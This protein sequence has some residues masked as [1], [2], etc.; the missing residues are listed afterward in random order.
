MH[1]FIN[2][3]CLYT[4]SQFSANVLGKEQF[5]A[6]YLC[7]G[8]FGSLASYLFKTQQLSNSMTVGASAAILGLLANTSLLAPNAQFSIIFLPFIKFS[9]QYFL[10]GIL[11]FDAAGIAL[12]WRVMDHAAHLGGTLFGWSVLSK[13]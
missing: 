2:M 12:G 6:L 5:L 4:F 9:A 7:S 13:I 8:L 10:Y 11:A 1:F 3:Y